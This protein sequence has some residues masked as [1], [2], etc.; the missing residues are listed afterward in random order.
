MVCLRPYINIEN[1]FDVKLFLHLDPIR[2]FQPGWG[3][4]GLSLRFPVGGS[5]YGTPKK[6]NSLWPLS[7]FVL[8]L[9][10]PCLMVTSSA[11]TIWELAGDVSQIRDD[12]KIK[13]LQNDNTSFLRE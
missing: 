5:A 11:S 10:T 3:E 13:K 1:I 9:T 4:V 6:L 12:Q 2:T 7:N 8:P